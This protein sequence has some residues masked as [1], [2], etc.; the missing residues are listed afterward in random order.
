[1]YS[2]DADDV[3]NSTT[4]LYTFCMV[5]LIVRNGFKGERGQNNTEIESTGFTETF[6][7]LKL[8]EVCLYFWLY[9]K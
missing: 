4:D 6:A 1:M 8:R 5:L 3:V 9:K 2:R 7:F